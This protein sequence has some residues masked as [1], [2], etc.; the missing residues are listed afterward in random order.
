MPPSNNTSMNEL[1]IT[2]IVVLYYS[3]HLLEPL[4]ANIT[5]KI[6]GLDEIIL[7]DNSN[8]D[9]SEFESC[10]V[11][12]IHPSQN[13]G[14]GAAIN[15][16]VKRA[17]NERI[18]IL[19]PDITIDQWQLPEELNKVDNFILSSKPQEWPCMRKFPGICY[20]FFRLALG[21]LGWPFGWVR[22]QYGGI[23]VNQNHQLQPVDWVSGSL[24][25]TNKATMAKLDG[26]DEKYF[27]FYEEVDLCKRASFLNI[28]RYITPLITYWTNQGTASSN[29]VNE[30]KF[31]SSIQSFQRYHSIYTGKH[32]SLLFFKIL[33]GYCGVIV[34]LLGFFNKFSNCHKAVAKERQ[35][36]IYYKNIL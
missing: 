14:Y 5:E 25:I 36:H 26:F 3:K 33:K 32:I 10:L 16:G 17:H 29:N 18:V 15:S 4:I 28:P 21:N 34:L 12:V 1:P 8:E 7:V 9:L 22:A 2:A 24:I 35:Y 20:D 19:N 27:L 13:I 6:K 11:K 23:P 31:S 30:I